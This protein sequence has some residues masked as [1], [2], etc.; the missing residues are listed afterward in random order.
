MRD[1]LPLVAILAAAIAVPAFAAA[2]KRRDRD[3]RRRCG[4]PSRIAR[5][6]RPIHFKLDA[7]RVQKGGTV[8]LVDKT[9]APHSFSLVKKSQVPTNA[10][11]VDNCFGKGPCDEI[12][13]AHG[14]VNPDTGEEQDPTT[15]LV[16]V[17][18]AGFNQPGDSVVSD[19]RPARP[20][21]GEQVN[22]KVT[23]RGQDALLH[24]CDSPVDERRHQR[25]VRQ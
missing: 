18:K 1:S 9:K 5:W 13:L 16:N 20:R 25:Q 15:P 22:L 19:R 17:G 21:R 10:R 23:R 11:P 12:A 3:H 24:L 7:V 14:A 6:R 4:V 8:T 2:P